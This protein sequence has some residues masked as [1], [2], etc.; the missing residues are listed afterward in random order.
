MRTS[1]KEELIELVAGIQRSKGLDELSSRLTGILFIETKELTLKE[2]AKR[3]GYSTSAVCTSMKFLERMGAVR[4]IRKP[5]SKRVYFY[6]EKDLLKMFM[7]ILEKIKANVSLIKSRM[8]GIIERYKM[9]RSEE[10]RE[11]LKIAKNYYRQVLMLERIM[12]KLMG[13]LK[14]AQNRMKNLSKL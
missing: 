11:E 14:E 1:P 8:P 6:M 10:S 13:A 12:K 7:Q 9:E 5:K 2:L 3:S 4:R